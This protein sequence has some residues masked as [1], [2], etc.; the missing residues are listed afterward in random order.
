MQQIL[1]FFIR[2]KNFLLFTLLFS[3]SIFL[4]IQTHAYHKNRFVNSSTYLTGSIY[5]LKSSITSYF[6][7]KKENTILIEENIRIRKEL[8]SYRK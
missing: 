6:S 8:E 4:T 2:N 3:I 7:L 1:F 5:S